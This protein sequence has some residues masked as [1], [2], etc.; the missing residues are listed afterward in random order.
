MPEIYLYEY[1]LEH[2][3]LDTEQPITTVKLHPSVEQHIRSVMA[4]IRTADSEYSSPPTSWVDP[5]LL[6]EAPDFLRGFHWKWNGAQ[7][8]MEPA[9]ILGETVDT[10]AVGALIHSW[11]TTWKSWVQS[12]QVQALAQIESLV[13][14]VN[15]L[16]QQD[17]LLTITS[18]TLAKVVTYSNGSFNGFG[19][20]LLPAILLRKLLGQTISIAIGEEEREI[21]WE[22]VAGRRETYLIS[23]LLY[24]D[25]RGAF[26]YKLEAHLQTVAGAEGEQP[27]LHLNLKQQRF[28]DGKIKFLPK[29]DHSILLNAGNGL[30]CKVS[31][32]DFGA[33]RREVKVGLKAKQEWDTLPELEALR[34]NPELYL[35]QARI[36]YLT[37]MKYLQGETASLHPLM[38]GMTFEEE[39][40]VMDPVLRQLHFE[41]NTIVE[42]DIK[43][44]ELLSKLGRQT[45]ARVVWSLDRLKKSKSGDPAAILR[46]RIMAATDDKG[47]EIILITHRSHTKLIDE[48]MPD[49]IKDV[50]SVQPQPSANDPDLWQIAPNI[51]CRIIRLSSDAYGLFEKLPYESVTEEEK[52]R[53]SYKR[54]RWLPAYR[55]RYGQ[56]VDALSEW[57][58]PTGGPVRFVLIE[59][60]SPPSGYAA[61]WQDVK[62]AIRAALA[63][64]GYLS[65]F[66][67]PYQEREDGTEYISKN[68]PHRVR[69]G[70]VDGLRQVGVVLGIPS[71]L[72]QLLELPVLDI[73]SM[74]LYQSGSDIFYPV[75]SRLSPDGTID[76]RYPVVGGMVTDWRPA[77]QAIPELIKMI[78]TTLDNLKVPGSYRQNRNI[79]SPLKL[80]NK[81]ILKAI[82]SVLDNARPT[83]AIV[84]AEKLRNRGVWS[85]LGNK[86]IGQQRSIFGYDDSPTFERDHPAKKHI[87]GIIRYRGPEREVPEY[88]PLRDRLGKSIDYLA[89]QA[90]FTEDSGF[91]RYLGVGVTL[92]TKVNRESIHHD[93][94]SLVHS[95][96]ERP[97][98]KEIDAGATQRYSHARLVE[99][100][101]FFVSETLGPA[102]DL[103]I[104][105]LA[106][107]TRMMGWHTT[108]LSSPWP[109][110]LASAALTDAL[111]VIA[112]YDKSD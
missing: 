98:G 13:A 53:R 51:T 105:R 107:L 62:G 32:E 103:K 55:H 39:W 112:K 7:Y 58:P 34:N 76:L 99:F 67:N 41:V 63:E 2:I 61:L 16:W 31:S 108:T 70:L 111:D 88:Y 1:P 3:N 77:Y 9:F 40:S 30:W 52:G 75:F 84:P 65:Q 8:A 100:V 78:W 25:N 47:L 27:V 21:T 69:Q 11:V 28:P 95:T 38:V 45:E 106:Q 12:S 74:I 35:N 15:N 33:V 36:I 23:Q 101:P 66:M 56:L 29:N 26:A 96:K 43:L 86:K 37:G 109:A 48:V 102:G 83:L 90:W 82:E 22:L 19:Y 17:Q 14:L 97:T 10:N 81:A 20:E 54:A 80:D 85:Q 59:K 79:S 18:S 4:A 73:V 64:L 94:H 71:E 104:L 44:E 6:V 50:F 93:A 46:D 92:S 49:A 91:Y 89:P 60:P 72:Y 68:A 5:L 24:S 42:L 110:H 57:L 87:L